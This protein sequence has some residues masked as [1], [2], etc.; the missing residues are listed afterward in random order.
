[1]PLTKNDARVLRVLADH[2]KF[3][4]DSPKVEADLRRIADEI[5]P[6]PSVP[7]L[8]HQLA[9]AISKVQEVPG[10]YMLDAFGLLSQIRTKIIQGKLRIDII[11]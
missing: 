4:K 5:D 7:L 9:A 11:E 6:G 8:E 3:N 10:V 1:V 2:L